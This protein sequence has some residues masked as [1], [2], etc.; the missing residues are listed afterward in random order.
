MAER[1]WPDLAELEDRREECARQ[2]DARE[3]V[4][5][6]RWERGEY[7]EPSETNTAFRQTL[8]DIVVK[9]LRARLETY[10]VDIVRM[11]QH[12]LAHLST[13]KVRAGW[14]CKCGASGYRPTAFTALRN[15]GEHV[16][17]AVW[18]A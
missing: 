12:D 18:G 17:E 2:V 14:L 8:R 3:K 13:G 9:N 1:L 4:I 6:A 7:G 10:D 5:A 16:M 11:R 15:H